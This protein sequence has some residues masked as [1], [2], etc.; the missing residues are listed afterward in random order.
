M[1]KTTPFV[2]A[3]TLPRKSAERESAAFAARHFAV[4]RAG[5]LLREYAR[6]QEQSESSEPEMAEISAA[7]KIETEPQVLV[8]APAPAGPSEEEIAALIAAA[9]ERGRQQALAEVSGGLD[10]VISALDVAASELE[11]QRREL[12][13]ALVVPMTQAS[14]DLAAQLARQQLATPEGLKSYLLQVEASLS[15]GLAENAVATD[16]AAPVVLA[17]L[18]P[19]DVDLLERAVVKPQSI[20]WQ[21]DPLVSRGGVILGRGDKVIDDRFENRLRDVREAALAAAAALTLESRS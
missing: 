20:R 15:E 1:R 9:E 10:A 5:F 19:E 6:Q 12:E 8:A 11:L 4:R 17:R 16:A 21:A 7:P 14:V 3:T 2:A 18:N 13:S